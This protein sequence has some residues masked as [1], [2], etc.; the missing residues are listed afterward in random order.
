MSTQIA[1]W[2]KVDFN[3]GRFEPIK[4]HIEAAVIYARL[5]RSITS[6][7]SFL[8]WRNMSAV[9]RH[10]LQRHYAIWK[11]SIFGFGAIHNNKKSYFPCSGL[12]NICR[13]SYQVVWYGRPTWC[14]V[15][16]GTSIR[17][18]RSDQWLCFACGEAVAAQARWESDFAVPISK[19]YFLSR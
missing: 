7:K 2:S 16:F 11:N 1:Q 10:Q 8:A 17:P 9:A 6:S 4:E 12:V 18:I 5:G 14:K 3:V 15:R 19:K 13:I